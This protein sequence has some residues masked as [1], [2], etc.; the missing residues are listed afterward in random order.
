[1]AAFDVRAGRLAAGAVRF[2]GSTHGYGSTVNPVLLDE[3]LN[4]SSASRRVAN[5][6]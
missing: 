3:V 5:L 6:A 1:V 4:C 2:T